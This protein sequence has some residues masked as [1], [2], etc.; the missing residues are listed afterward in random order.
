MVLILNG[1][2]AEYIKEDSK[3]FND[4]EVTKRIHALNIPFKIPVTDD[5]MIERSVYVYLIFGDNIYL[6][7][8]GVAGAEKI[9]YE[10][11]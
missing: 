1:L 10:Y 9:I 3:R 4:M 5:V 2:Y 7:D 6:I 11:R 8:S